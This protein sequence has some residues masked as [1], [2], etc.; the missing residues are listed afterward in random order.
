MNFFKALIWPFKKLGKLTVSLLDE[1][2]LTDDVVELAKKL[3]QEAE[4]KF[5]D[6]T[7]KREWV[8]KA[9]MAAGVPS[10]VARIAVELGVRLFKK[11]LK[12][13]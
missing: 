5:L 4:A 9:L 2:D 7:E 1:L 13:L 3:V 10:V 11:Q 8:I 6:N 12:G